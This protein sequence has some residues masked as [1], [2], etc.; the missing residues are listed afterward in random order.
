[1]RLS[2]YQKP[3]TSNISTPASLAALDRNSSAAGKIINYRD[4]PIAMTDGAKESDR[5]IWGPLR[6]VATDANTSR[7]KRL[8]DALNQLLRDS[9]SEEPEASD[10]EEEPSGDER[11]L[12]DS[13]QEAEDDGDS[14]IDEEE[15]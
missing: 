6:R 3:A 15:L 4:T 13:A 2:D 9:D 8:H 14:E 11:D 5:Q 12:E 7:K 10:S 1:M